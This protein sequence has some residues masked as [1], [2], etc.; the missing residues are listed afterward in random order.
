MRFVVEF[1]RQVGFGRT[2][3]AGAVRAAALRHEAFDHAVEFHAVVKAFLRQFGDAL[4][5]LGGKIGAQLDDNVA[6]VEMHGQGF[7]HR[8]ES[9][10]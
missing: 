8:R 7:G 2:A 6:A 1:L 4:D 5:M 3:G 10:C 9:F